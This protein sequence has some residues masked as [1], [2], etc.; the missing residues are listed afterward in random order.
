MCVC[1]CVCVW[2]GVGMTPIISLRGVSESFRR[3]L[4]NVDEFREVTKSMAQSLS[5]KVW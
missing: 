3:K 1:V 2:G 5:W 4:Y